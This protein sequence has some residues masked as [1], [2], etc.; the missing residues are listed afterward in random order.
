MAPTLLDLPDEMLVKIFNRLGYEDF[1]HH[2]TDV[3]QIRKVC[4][5][6]LRVLKCVKFWGFSLCKL[7]AV[8]E[9]LEGVRQVQALRLSIG[10]DLMEYL[11]YLAEHHPEVEHLILEQESRGADPDPTFEKKPDPSNFDL[12]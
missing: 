11:P 6:F 9:G 8:Q 12:T 4:T 10:D 7:E 5:R 1:L 3:E 2:S